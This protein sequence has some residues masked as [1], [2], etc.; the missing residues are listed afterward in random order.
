MPTDTPVEQGPGPARPLLDV[1]DVHTRIRTA[2]ADIWP[3]NGV[4]FA[5]DP[6]ERLGLVGESGSGKSMTTLTLARLLPARAQVCSGQ[7][8]LEGTDLLALSEASMREV[9]GSRIG[10]VFQDS[11]TSL[12]P[13]LTVGYQVAE[14]LRVHRGEGR[15]QARETAVGLLDQVGIPS[16][17]QRSRDY[18]HELSGG[19]RQRVAIALAIACR[20]QLIIADEPT[21]ALDVSVQAQILDLLSELATQT[22]TA[23][24]LITHDLAA[25]SEFCDR[26]AVMYAGRIVEIAPAEVVTARARMPYTRALLECVPRLDEDL[27]TVAAPIEGLPPSLANLPPGCS[28]Q[29]R[30][31][32]ARPECEVAMPELDLVTPGHEVRCV[33]ASSGGWL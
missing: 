30:C 24:L 7:V 1:R 8:L 9:R 18:P 6:G 21:T 16:P 14:T 11:T 19:M 33:G 25:A 23:V 28:F 13:T 4:S 32:V 31:P 27:E 10:F 15:R 17:R 12:N 3:V 5:L 2:A 26:I 22:G 29:P 20:P